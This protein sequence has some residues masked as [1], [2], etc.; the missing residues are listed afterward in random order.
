M[1]VDWGLLNTDN[2]VFGKAM[3]GYDTGQKMADQ[4][5]TRQ[6][7]NVFAVD[8]ARGAQALITAGRPDLAEAALKAKSTSNTAQAESAAQPYAQRGDFAGAAT[9]AAGYD[10]STARQLSQFSQEQLDHAQKTGQRSA[11]VLMSA[12][13]LPDAQSRKSFI[14]QHTDELTGLGYSPDQIANYDTSDPLKM[15]ADAARFM[16]LAEVAGKVSVQKFGDNVVAYDTNPIAGTKAV[17]KTPIP[18]TRADQR[19]DGEFSYRQQHDTQEIGL[20]EREL[21]IQQ[22]REQREAANAQNPDSSPSKV[23]GPIF[24]KLANGVAL[25]AGEQ[26]ALKYYKMD[27]LTADAMTQSG[28]D[29]GQDMPATATRPAM[30]PVPGRTPPKAAPGPANHE[31]ALTGGNAAVLPPRARAQLSE[32]IP[33]T[34]QNGEKWVL[35]G[36]QPVF[37]GKAG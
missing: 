29:N 32:G 14:T 23:M 36:G 7:L 17:S 4:S 34:F 37:L 26:A 11:T 8:P 22:Q 15:R 21:Q 24:R 33:K 31:P 9:A 16:S 12:A 30:P 10:L 27:P 5:N 1:P 13:S 28:D 19:A 20:R 18:P 35:R 3:Q 6:A 2:N 25:S